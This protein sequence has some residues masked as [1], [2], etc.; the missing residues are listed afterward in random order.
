MSGDHMAKA[1]NLVWFRRLARRSALRYHENQT[2][3]MDME[4]L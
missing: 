3:Y 2:H 1:I 4:L